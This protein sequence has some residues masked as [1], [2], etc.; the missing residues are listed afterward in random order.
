MSEDEQVK[1]TSCGKTYSTENASSNPEFLGK[2]LENIERVS[3][4]TSKSLMKDVKMQASK[5]AGEGMAKTETELEK[6]AGFNFFFP[7]QVLKEFYPEIQHEIVDYPNAN[8]QPMAL[9]Q[10]GITGDAGHELEGVLDEALD[11]GIVEMI[12][13][14]ADVGEVEPMAMAAA[15]YAPTKPGGAMGIGRDGKPETLEGV[16]LRKENDIRGMMFTD[17]FYGQYEGIPGAALAVASQKTAAGDE[18]KQFAMFLK[19]VCG[20]IAATMVAAF[21]VTSRPLLDKV[22][23]VG[24]VQLDQVEQLPT[25]A[26]TA[27]TV[28]PITPGGSRVK[29]L[30]GKL[31]DG[32]IKAA[33]NGAWAQAAVWNDAPDGGFIYEVFVRPETIDTDSMVMKYK[34]IAGTRE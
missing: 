23:G 18:K 29:Y 20:E 6:E 12:Q 5:Q 17:E 10:P 1:C 8:N 28:S 2:L 34:F 19:K 30:L 31:N 7:G 26:S 11:T 16:P 25:P 14:P 27:V 24:E 4:L 9:E 15:D 33:I 22:P 13:L 3:P 32:D 21:R